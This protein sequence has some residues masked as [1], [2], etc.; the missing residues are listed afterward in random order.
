MPGGTAYSNLEAAGHILIREATEDTVLTVPN[1]VG[2]EGSKTIPIPKGTQVGS[3]L[4]HCV[5]NSSLASG[6]A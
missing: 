2:E 1:P 3:C 4:F 5:H 6:Y